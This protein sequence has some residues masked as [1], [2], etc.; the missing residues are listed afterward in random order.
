[1]KLSDYFKPKPYNPVDA[2]I[3][4]VTERDIKV[5]RMQRA[6]VCLVRKP[7]CYG[8]GA[9]EPILVR[10]TRWPYQTYMPPKSSERRNRID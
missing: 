9:V 8:K 10:K 2:L 7:I 5:E 3:R 4:K 1:M 6:Q